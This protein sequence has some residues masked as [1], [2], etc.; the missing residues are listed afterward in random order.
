MSGMFRECENITKLNLSKLK[1]DNTTDMS[2]MFGYC[3]R[4]I[5]CL[6]L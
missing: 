4:R 5:R 1:T 6:K 3:I 2:N